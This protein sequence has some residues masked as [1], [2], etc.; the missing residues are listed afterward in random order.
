MFHGE[1]AT[2][3]GLR[4]I[5]G[6]GRVPFAPVRIEFAAAVLMAFLRLR[7]GNGG[8]RTGICSGRRPRCASP[9]DLSP[10]SEGDVAKLLWQIDIYR[11]YARKLHAA[12]IED[13]RA[14]RPGT[15]VLKTDVYEESLDSEYGLLSWLGQNAGQA[16]GIDKNEEVARRAAANVS[17]PGVPNCNAIVC[18]VRR[19]AAPDGVFDLVIST[20]TLDHFSAESDLAASLGQI[21]RILKPAGT[22]VLTMDNP[23]NPVIAV[24]NRLPSRMLR[25]LAL[26]PYPMGK[27]YSA[28]KL[29]RILAREGFRLEKTE[30]VMHAPRVLMVLAQRLA[31][32]LR[33]DRLAG[34]LLGWFER[35]E[36]LRGRGLA[37]RTGHFIALRATKPP[38]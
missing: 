7:P 12:L 28:A 13:S 17:Q 20:S 14:L 34:A 11:L 10:R 29:S 5:A 33:S 35:F 27:A 26:I 3:P 18:D 6:S 36:G 25:R 31:R 23:E 30:F 8:C 38:E 16:I 32:R 15:K 19:I 24:R 22:V 9:R 21:L 1:A 37:R 4:T 2:L